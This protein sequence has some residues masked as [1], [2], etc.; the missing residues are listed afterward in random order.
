M[1]AS[2][3]L[4]NYTV[5]EHAEI[6][7]SDVEAANTRDETIKL[8]SKLLRRYANPPAETN[9]PLEFAFHLA[10]DLRQRRVLD[11]GCGSGVN[12]V[13][14]A[15]KGADVVG[16]DISSSLRHIARRRAELTGV[17]LPTFVAASA[18][19]MPLPSSSVDVVF[20][21]AILH[22]LDLPA[23]SR[24]IHRVLRPG[25]RAIFQ[26]PIRNSE[27]VKRLRAAIPYKAEDVSPFEHPLTDGELAEFS[28]NFV[29]RRCRS[30][31]L[32]HVNI[33]NVLP[34]VRNHV[35]RIYALDGALLRRFAYLSRF[36]GIR[37]F[38]LE[39]R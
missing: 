25:G 15:A 22:H 31:S 30:F 19:S 16:V 1:A 9:Y 27:L 24:E 11:F 6:V 21:I 26:E 35:D 3:G 37:V 38:E 14:L 28:R 4:T 12:S 29:M 34:I 8:G 10:G 5:W 23:A 32:P 17:P 36:A 13:L 7:R 33:S 2:E 20:G 39:K 18:Y